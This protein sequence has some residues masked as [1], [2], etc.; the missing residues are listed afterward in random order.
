[1]EKIPTNKEKKQIELVEENLNVAG[2]NLVKE[3]PLYKKELFVESK[4]I[5]EENLKNYFE[6]NRFLSRPP[7]PLMQEN[8]TTLFVSSGIQVLDQSI[9]EEKK[10]PENPIFV[11]QP[12]LRSQFLGSNDIESHTSF[13]NVTTLDVNLDLN[14][15]INHLKKW[16]QFLVSQGFDENEFVFDILESEPKWGKRK[17]SNIVIGVYYG[18]LDIGDAIYIP[19]MPQDDRDPFSISDIGFGL[20]RLNHKLSDI[21]TIEK[22]CLKTLALLAISGVNPGN[23]SHGYRFRLFSKRFVSGCDLDFERMTTELT[24]M[25]TMM[26]YWSDSISDSMRDKELLTEK[27]IIECE[28]NFNREIL[29]FLKSE[30]NYEHDIEINQKTKDFLVQ[31]RNIGDKSTDFWDDIERKINIK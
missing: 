10:L 12:V 17:F 3:K 14:E 26:D 4:N 7:L 13:H 2:F 6:Q 23:K 30:F 5:K 19:S 11:N 18:G 1:M 21:N 8:S 27:I 29:N 22:D 31:L 15:H 28:R 24:S 20:E 16:I 9:H 25:G